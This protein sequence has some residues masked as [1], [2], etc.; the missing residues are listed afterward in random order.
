M[1]KGERERRQ[2]KMRDNR[3][4]D[5][6]EGFGRKKKQSKWRKRIRYYRKRR[7]KERKVNFIGGKIKIKLKKMVR[8]RNKIEWKQN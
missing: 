3:R 4:E 1:R 8:E 2:T 5:R 7:E 6:R